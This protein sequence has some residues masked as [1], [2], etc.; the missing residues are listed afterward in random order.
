LLNSH[1][2]SWLQTVA[3]AGL[4]VLQFMQ[5]LQIAVYNVAPALHQLLRKTQR[6]A[7]VFQGVRAAGM[8]VG[9]LL[10]PSALVAML[11]VLPAQWWNLWQVRKL[12]TALAQPAQ[13]IDP[14]VRG[15]VLAVVRRVMPGAIYYALSG[16]ITVWLVSIFGTTTTLA[17]VGALSRL[18]QA[19]TLVSSVF[20]VLLIP[21]FSRLRAGRAHLLGRY[22][23]VL[24][25]AFAVGAVTCTAAALY[26]RQILW[27][28]GKSYAG[29]ESEVLLQAAVGATSLLAGLAFQLGAV[30][31]VVIK[32]TLSIPVEILVQLS[33][34]RFLAFDTAAGVLWFALLT[35]GVQFLMHVG[36]FL[37]TTLRSTHEDGHL[38]P[39]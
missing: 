38:H 9:T 1:G 29:L 15:R 6:I 22:G 34:M 37:Y 32:P 2:A 31:S 24:G 16:Q 5:A 30:R 27:I 20:G 18:S 3:L 4:V 12:S 17:E 8:V 28:L 25:L 10:A 35:A 39:I 21:R 11:S 26:P 23:Q 19:L 33:V 14:E 36:Y 13:T 7:V